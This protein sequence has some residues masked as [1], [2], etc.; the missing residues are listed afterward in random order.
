[1]PHAVSVMDPQE[2]KAL[3]RELRAKRRAVPPQERLAAARRIARHID[4]AFHLRAGQRV[5]VYASLPEELDTTPLI[6]LLQARG[7]RVY[8]PRIERRTGRMQFVRMSGRMR[9]NHLGIVEPEGT[10]IISPRWLSI[11]FAPLVGFDSHGMRLG[12]GGGFY[13]R[14]FAFRR[15]RD[16]WRGPRLIGIAYELQRLP[17]IEPAPHDVRL[18][19]VVTERGIT[20]CVTG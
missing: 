8:L 20:R 16:A 9:R 5:A 15:C 4:H 3:R 2:R 7:C 14:T 6:D 13:D 11:V 17:A 12:M 1:M 18:D 10:E 19:A